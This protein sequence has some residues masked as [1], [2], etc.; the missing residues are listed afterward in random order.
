M[1][2][3]ADKK[4]PGSPRRVRH[5][6]APLAGAFSVFAA[7]TFSVPAHAV[8]WLFE[9]R[10]GAALTFTDNVDQAP[11][12]EEEAFILSATPGFSLRTEGSR[13]VEAVID[14][15]LTGVVR[16]AGNND[17][18][19]FHNL[20]AGGKAEVVED[21]F[22]VDAD[23]RVSQ[24]FISLLGSQSD[25]IVNSSNITTSVS[26]NLSPYIR[27]RFSTF[28]DLEA[29]YTLYGSH[30][31]EGGAT[32]LLTNQFTVALDS[33]TRFDDLSWGLNY[34]YRDVSAQDTST[35]ADSYV[36]QRADLSLGYAL[37]RKFRL[38]GNVGQEKL[39]YEVLTTNDFDD[40]VWSAGFSWTPSRRSSLEAT[41]GQRFYGDTYSVSARYRTRESAWNVSYV[42][43]INDISRTM[44]TEGTLYLYLCPG[45]DP[46][47]PAQFVVS[48]FP[49]AP[50]P[51]CEFLGS[52]PS[53][54]PSI[55]EGLYV[56]KT[57][58]AGVN[59]GVRK[60]TYSINLSD[61][62]R[63][64]LLQGNAEDRSQTVNA[65]VNYR[66]SALTN[67][68][69]NLTLGWVEDAGVLTGLGFDR[70]DDTLSVTVGGTH[71]FSTDLTGALTFRHY[72]RDSNDPASE[73]T[74]NNI[75]ASVNM[76]F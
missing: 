18:D 9:P 60:V 36:Y 46:T 38:I 42:E 5:R 69:G 74:E 54:L 64:Y 8:D 2:V 66:L 25:P 57:F 21:F 32:D 10:I 43:D 7:I 50:A 71:R 52:Q 49:V 58:R 26:Y 15:S 31:D 65:A 14:Y 28:A 13:R 63:I 19:L 61:V 11:A 4:R 39:E 56:S 76:R 3:T 37:T 75:T 55:A 41:A 44:L 20:V 12:N 16:S 23:A 17:N 34:Q 59:W 53:L 72:Q 68:Y 22:F 70:E 35:I 29:R 45:A 40:S 24:E 33:G 67:V 30:F 1:A 6:Q 73:Y 62:Q 48:P 47:D 27:Q 51:G